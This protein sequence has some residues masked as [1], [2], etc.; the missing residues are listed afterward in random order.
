MVTVR[1]RVVTLL[2]FFS[3][4][5]ALLFLRLSYLEVIAGDRLF[6]WAIDQRQSIIPILADRGEILD[7]NLTKLAVSMSTDAVFAIPAEV[8][9][10]EDTAAKLA[11]LLQLDKEWLLDRLQKRQRMVWLK[12]R[13]DPVTARAVRELELPGIDI[14]VRPQRFYPHDELA[15]Q[16][17]GFAGID[18]QGLEGL[19]AYYDRYLRGV[20]GML[21]QERDATGR[22]IPGTL[23][24]HIPPLSGNSLVL[25]ID[26]VIQ[27]IAERELA[28]AVQE[29]NS[30][31]G[32]SIFVQPKTGEILAMAVYPSFN[33]NYYSSWT[34]DVWRNRAVTDQFE[35][36]STFKVV[37]GVSALEAGVTRLDEVFVDPIHLSRWGGRVNCWRSQGHGQQTL[38]EATENSCNPIF[39]ILAADRL[40]PQKFYRYASAFGFGQKTGIDLPGEAVGMLPKPGDTRHGEL[41]QWANIGFG[42]GVAVTPLQMAMMVSA[43]ANDGKLMRPHIVKEI[44]DRNGKIVQSFPPEVV[45]QV[46]SKQVANDFAKVM[47]SVVVNGSGLRAEVPGYRVA[48]KTGTAEMPSPLGGYSDDRIASFIGFAPVDDPQ[49]AGVVMLVKIGVRPAYGGT[50]A[51]P[52]FSAVVGDALEYMQVARKAEVSLPNTNGQAYVPNVQNLPRS[53]ALNVLAQAGLQVA[54]TGTGEYVEQQL[55]RPGAQVKIGSTVQLSFETEGEAC[56]EVVVPDVV[57]RTMRDAAVSLGQAGLV[58]VV[59]GSGIATQQQP[60]AGTHVECGER[61]VV[62]FTLPR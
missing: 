45:R 18:N 1:K 2:L 22:I 46:I 34:A 21:L 23:E 58:I 42:Q 10:V 49:I 11:P 53:E 16:L 37:T 8:K 44:R 24:Q 51:A 39:A 7:R 38:V 30:E 6:S 9:D 57:G 47:R 61:V 48:G 12:L 33:P 36:G 14:V 59:E 62:K 52:V 4:V 55:P 19:E 17:L 25:T 26:H 27:Y 40:G 3:G 13:V 5:F 50:W 35:P 43:L 60:A 29:T 56:D 31:F 15:A 20:D 41:L 32:I 54:C 28:K